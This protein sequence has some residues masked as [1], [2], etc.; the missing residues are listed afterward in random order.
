MFAFGSRFFAQQSVLWL[1]IFQAYYIIPF[2]TVAK[3]NCYV[4]ICIFQSTAWHISWFHNLT[5]VRSATIAWLRKY[6]YRKLASIALYILKSVI[7]VSY[8]CSIL[9]LWGASIL[10]SIV[11]ELVYIPP[12]VHS[13]P[14]PWILDGICCFLG[15]CLRLVWDG[16][17]VKFWAAFPWWSRMLSSFCIVPGHMYFFF[18]ELPSSLTH[19]LDWII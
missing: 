3:P 4:Y 9:F 14:F 8:G 10:I 18:G 16:V 6:I 17:S 7:A 13:D 19:L 11:P 15:F 12:A 1:H 5:S 2:L